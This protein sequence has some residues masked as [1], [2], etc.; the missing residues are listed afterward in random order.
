MLL[1]SARANASTGA[2]PNAAPD[3]GA[4]VPPAASA[5]H[6]IVEIKTT[7]D[8]RVAPLLEEDILVDGKR[9]TGHT[10]GVAAGTRKMTVTSKFASSTTHVEKKQVSS[11]ITQTRPCGFFGTKMC[12]EQVPVT[13]MIEQPVT[14]VTPVGGCTADVP[15]DAL[16]NAQYE[17]D[18]AFHDANACELRCWKTSPDGSRISCDGKT[19]LPAPVAAI[20]TATPSKAASVSKKKKAR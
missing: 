8:K 15:L 5:P 10:V 6:A 7:Y 9:V 2:T 13:K 4:F 3:A 20:P 18:Y 12:K 17:L 19:V 14:T 16:A 1:V 11:F